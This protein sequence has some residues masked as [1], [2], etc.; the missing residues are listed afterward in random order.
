LS[1]A[2]S[3]CAPDRTHGNAEFLGKL[4]FRAKTIMLDQ[5]LPLDPIN[6]SQEERLAEFFV[7]NR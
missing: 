6:D 2:Y 3:S 1:S 4:P 7:E 5:L